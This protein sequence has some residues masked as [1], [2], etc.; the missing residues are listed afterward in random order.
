LGL[1]SALGRLLR[2]LKTAGVPLTQPISAAMRSVDVGE[3]T[4]YELEPF[5]HDRPL[6]FLETDRG[7][8]KTISAPHMIATMLHHLELEIG[9]EVLILGAKG[10]YIAALIAHIVGPEGGVVVVDPSREVVDHVRERLEPVSETHTVRVR[11][12]RR[13]DFCPPQLP[14][15][16]DR[17]LVTGS[18]RDLPAW[19]ETRM[20]D[21]GFAVAPMGGRIAQRLVKRERVGPDWMDTDL[22]GVLFG[23]VDIADT[24]PEPMSAASLSE[25]LHEGAVLGEEIGLFDVEILERLGQLASALEG[26][27]DDLEPLPHQERME[28]EPP[29]ALDEGAW[30]D[31]VHPVVDLLTAEMDWLADIWPVLIALIDVR[32]VHPGQPDSDDDDGRSGGF[33]RHGDL[34]P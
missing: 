20:C 30:M 12:M 27:P 7:G 22:G 8:V 21:G 31:E 32:M 6:V 19:L 4:D 17:V 24:E 13:L 26:L 1:M 29:W 34:V 15:P 11:K 14:E 18:L 28:D 9:Q 2:R 23:P 25:L 5:F 10:G 16:L 3:F 33:G